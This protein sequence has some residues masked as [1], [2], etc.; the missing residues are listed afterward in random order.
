M[1]LALAAGL[2]SLLVAVGGWLRVEARLEQRHQRPLPRLEIDRSTEAIAHGRHLAESITL[3]GHCHGADLGGAPIVDL[4]ALAT[5]WAPNLTAG[6]GGVASRR[7]TADLARAVRYGVD[8]EGRTLLAMPSEHLGVLADRDLAAIL[9]YL[10]TVVPV[11][12]RV[13]ARSVGPLARLSLFLERGTD[14]IS[15]ERPLPEPPAEPPRR[16]PDARYGAYL[17]RVGLCHLC[18]HED[19]AGGLHPL[20]LPDE[21]VPADLR[22]QGPLL[23]WTRDDFARAL[24]TGVTPNGRH[25]DP[26]FMPWPRYAGL[27]ELEIDALWA[28]LRSL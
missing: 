1:K 20:A 6:I 25:L 2:L 7:S 23:R 24:R 16:G 26:A 22:P 8:P 15:A 10:E 9:A 12:R 28:Y 3:C 5:L 19:L 21:P 13:P 17:A 18:H 14:V 11:E 4:P 27:E